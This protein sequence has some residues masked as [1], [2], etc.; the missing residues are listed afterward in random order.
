M[1][2][3]IWTHIPTSM[4]DNDDDDFASP[5]AKKKP[6]PHGASKICTTG[7]KAK[8]DFALA[9][10]KNSAKGCDDD[11]N[12]DEIFIGSDYATMQCSPGSPV[13]IMTCQII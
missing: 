6:A 12:I 7:T 13:Y 10:K 9:D 2:R 1:A 3:E 8:S 5:I 11:E 4:E